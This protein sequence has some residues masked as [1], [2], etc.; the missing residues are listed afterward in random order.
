LESKTHGW[1]KSLRNQ[2][3]IMQTLLVIFCVHSTAALRLA[4][5]H[6]DQA[7]SKSY[8]TELD[9]A[10][11]ELYMDAFLFPDPN[12]EKSVFDAVAPCINKTQLMIVGFGN[13]AGLSESKYN[14]KFDFGEA[15]PSISTPLK[16]YPS[17][18]QVQVGF[19]KQVLSIC[20]IPDGHIPGEGVSFKFQLVKGEAVK[21]QW[22]S[23]K[24]GWANGEN[25]DI[26]AK[27]ARKYRLAATHMIQNAGPAI[28]EWLDWHIARGIE[29]FFL[30]DNN[31][32]EKDKKYTL[33][34]EKKGL[35][36]RVNW[37]Y[38]CGGS[39]K[40]NH[41][42]RGHLNHVLFKFGQV[43]DWIVAI[44]NDE[45]ISSSGKNLQD[46]VANV[47][48]DLNIVGMHSI[49]MQPGCEEPTKA[50]QPVHMFGEVPVTTECMPQ[51][52]TKKYNG[53]YFLRSLGA[54]KDNFVY[55]TPHPEQLTGIPAPTVTPDEKVAKVP[56]PHMLKYTEELHLN[57]FRSTYVQERTKSVMAKDNT[58]VQ[59][60]SKDWDSYKQSLAANA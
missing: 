30:Y 6:V 54:Y 29:H 36:T 39:K 15:S 13:F 16:A 44:D 25:N 57:H 59:R 35:V 2:L 12:A 4:N 37:P 18:C 47:S 20:D 42:Q 33:P 31:S 40:N 50:G 8:P 27:P 17:E 43:A 1:S 9:K 10:F 38:C 7:S 60:F 45:F 26:T 53:K 41:A 5:T 22:H 55:W 24:G 58:L 28:T 14:C 34:Y 11:Q 46:F 19:S 23:I 48:P 49:I 21:G 51:L 52:T 56:M 3:G 32:E